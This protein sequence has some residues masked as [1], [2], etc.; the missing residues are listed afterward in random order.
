MSNKLFQIYG[1]SREQRQKFIDGDENIEILNENFLHQIYNAV[2]LSDCINYFNDQGEKDGSFSGVLSDE[3]AGIILQISSSRLDDIES[4]YIKT[5]VSDFSFEEIDNDLL[6]QIVV[7]LYAAVEMLDK[8]YQTMLDY[9]EDLTSFKMFTDIE[10]HIQ[11]NAKYIYW[12]IL[13]LNNLRNLKIEAKELNPIWRKGFDSKNIPS[14]D[15]TLI[16]RL[17][18]GVLEILEQ[19]KENLPTYLKE[20][21]LTGYVDPVMAIMLGFLV[22][23]TVIHREFNKKWLR[24][25]DSYFLDVLKIRAKQKDPDRTVLQFQSYNVGDT[26]EQLIKKDTSFIAGAD[27]DTGKILFKN[28]SDIYVNNI[29][30]SGMFSLYGKRDSRISPA[31]KLDLITGIYITKLDDSIEAN[32]SSP[33]SAPE[34]PMFSDQ[35]ADENTSYFSDNLGLIIQSKNIQLPSGSREIS[36]CL[37]IQSAEKNSFEYRYSIPYILNQIQEILA[38]SY[39]EAYTKVFSEI[40][41][42]ELSTESGYEIVNN[43][44]VD[45]TKQNGEELLNVFIKVED[46]FPEIVPYTPDFENQLTNTNLEY[47]SI[48]ITMNPE[49]W[50]YPYSWLSNLHIDSINLKLNVSNINLSTVSTKSGAVSTDVPYALF[51]LTPQKGD[52]M[53]FSDYNMARFGAEY[54]DLT[55]NWMGIPEEENGFYDYYKGYPIEINNQSFK[56]KF[57][58]LIGNSWVDLDDGKEHYLYRTS[59]SSDKPSALGKLKAQTRF[60]LINTSKFKPVEYELNNFRYTDSCKGGFL[61]MVLVAPYGGFANDTFMRALQSTEELI[62]KKPKPR[63]VL[64]QPFTPNASSIKINYKTGKEIVK[65]YGKID[66]ETSLF[67]FSPIHLIKVYPLDRNLGFSFLYKLNYSKNI[68]LNL[69]NVSPELSL[70]LYFNIRNSGCKLYANKSNKTIWSIGNGNVWDELIDSD[71]DTTM[72]FTRSGVVQLQMPGRISSQLYTNPDTKS[73]LLRAELPDDFEGI[74]NLIAVYNNA[75]FVYYSA[76]KNVSDEIIQ[77]GFP[78]GTINSSVEKL[79]NISQITQIIPSEGGQVVETYK[80]IKLRITESI[81]NKNRAVIGPDYEQLILQKFQYV[82]KVKCF[83]GESRQNINIPGYLCI[84]VFVENTE[85]NDGVIH[86][87]SSEKLIDIQNY[88]K[89]FASPFAKIDVIN[90]IYEKI[91]VKSD[92]KFT[93]DVNKPSQKIKEINRIL[94]NYIAP[95]METNSLPDLGK[96]IHFMDILCTVRDFEGVES[97]SNFSIIVITSESNREYKL[98]IF[99]E[100]RNKKN[101]L[102]KPSVPWSILVPVS[103]NILFYNEYQKQEMFGLNLM[104]IGQTFII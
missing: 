33:M 29:N 93:P 32:L 87:M 51:G 43:S 103:Q 14:L 84:V 48:R 71:E 86:N 88:I 6:Q 91:L 24:F 77:S 35:S 90:P 10:Y 94:I 38:F 89:S 59:D 98:D 55:I 54:I 36:L 80:D 12:D 9:R 73:I 15:S 96:E 57:Q 101:M 39:E 8:W 37:K 61:R 62:G 79:N 13:Y 102:I 53:I 67:H 97:V 20:V 83:N 21:L 42:I 68:F 7:K 75:G 69:D 50:L 34:N 99:S 104:E 18:Y 85:V 58:T 92:I 47:A 74:A 63:A 28:K 44:R 45:W 82:Q 31:N 16:T 78:A 56:V 46:D 41:R 64:N 11:S 70:N 95:W 26:N 76:N 23:K 65:R 52:Y 40:I 19:L 81:S 17:F 22:N 66:K 72:T 30:L 5:G 2:D 25:P 3:I 4:E 60:R 100:E 49:A 1:Y 27:K